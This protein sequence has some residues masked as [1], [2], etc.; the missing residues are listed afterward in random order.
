MK[1][2]LG[3]R[4]LPDPSETTKGKEALFLALLFAFNHI[5]AANPQIHPDKPNEV[6]FPPQEAQFIRMVIL[7]TDGGGEPCIDELEVYGAS[8]ERN[9]A[10]SEAGSEA[11]A[12]SCLAGH[13]IHRIE[14]LNDGEYG[15]SFSWIAAGG[16]EEWAQID[17]PEATSVAKVVFSRDRH[18]VFRDRTPTRFEIHLSVDGKEWQVVKKVAALSAGDTGSV[19]S[20]PPPPEIPTR[21]VFPRTEADET[22][23]YA[24]L[25]EEHA[26]L[27]TYG[28]ADLS[29][30][31]VPYNGRVKEYPRHVADDFL[32]LP[33]LSSEPEL[34]GLPTDA[35][36]QEASLGTV[37]VAHPYEFE[38][39]PLVCHRLRAGR[40]EGFLYL[41]LDTDRLLSSH[42][43]VV[44]S[45]DLQ[46]C[47][48]V[49]CGTA[50]LAFN[51]YNHAGKVVSIT[52]VE[53]AV[54]EDLTSFEMR[55][56]LSLFPKCEEV[57]VRVG[58]GMGGQHTP[59]M[60]RPIE[61]AFS[62]L[63]IA[64]VGEPVSGVCQVRVGRCKEAGDAPSNAPGALRLKHNIPGLEDGMSL[65]PGEDRVLTISLEKGPIG[66]QFDLEIGA[67][68]DGPYR[69]HLFRYDPLARTLAL[70]EDLEAR[71]D[72]KG[73]DVGEVPNGLVGLRKRQASLQAISPPDVASER[74]AFFEARNLKRRLFLRDPDLEPV[75]RVLF[76][77]RQPFLPSHNYS[78]CF[79]APFRPGGGIC[80]LEIPLGEDAFDPN[81]AKTTQLFDAGSG[82]A[83]TPMADYDLSK[84]YFAYRPS[85]EGYYHVMSVNPDGTGLKQITQGPFHDYWPCP[86]PDGDLAFISTRCKG[87]YLCWRPQA[88]VMFRMDREGGN[89]RPLSYANLTEWAPSVMS[90][91]RLIWTRSEYIDKGADFS[92][93]LWAIRPDGTKPELVF[94][95]TIIQPNGYAN[96]REVPDTHEICCT[97]ISHFGD[98]NGPI[99][100][101]DIDKG[102]FNQKA[103]ASITPEV[104]WPG[105]W[106]MEEC[107]RD[108][109][110]ISR[111]LILCSHA[112]RDT[113]GIYTIDRFGDRE[114]L[115]LDPDI[116]C[117]CPTPLR[118]TLPPPIIS[119][120]P[121]EATEFGE[122]VLADA[123]RGIDGAVERGRV[124]YLRVIEEVRN[125]LERLPN[126][127]YR[128]DHEP[129]MNWYVSP[130]DLVSGPF[131]WPTYVAKTS[132][133]VV[134]V[135]A[136][137]SARFYAPAGKTLYFEILDKDFNEL[138]RMRSVVQI[139][140]GE[141]RSCIGC[142][143]TRQLSPP[144]NHRLLA[145][146][147]KALEPPPWG[148]RPFNFQEVVQPV[149]D[150]KCT[151][152][153]NKD[154]EAA[155]DL[156]ATPDE[157]GIPASYRTMIAKGLV[158]Y[159][160]Y[161]WNSGGCEKLEPLTFGTVKSK[162][163]EVL[164]A[165]HHEVVLTTEEMRRLKE[166]TDLN[167]PLWPDYRDRRER[168][169][170][171]GTTQVK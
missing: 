71:L 47:G 140:P 6:C 57:G 37:R 119:D 131:G 72:R 141:K 135:E 128:K 165:G 24:F 48:V 35:C 77:K 15:N 136:D 8:G 149:L 100:L 133:G 145:A 98:L 82:I 53:A 90:D 64:P 3:A 7:E 110:P 25:G 113:F 9:L 109:F 28:R 95:N 60:G 142:H 14:H 155:I 49:V 17:L 169:L 130:V 108:A 88:A 4:V 76:A 31:L 74:S 171:L 129:F 67:D 117:M 148:Q 23:E 41:F 22:L 158:N 102:R 86:L 104:P 61:F 33:P 118:R 54:S 75:R 105:N 150:A 10:S 36:W 111:D 147:P 94:G 134:P 70:A 132:W 59:G 34:D 154:H 138:Q 87:R 156:T 30:R 69:L 103:I 161:G 2:W 167:C 91:G 112:P 92:H 106:P 89:M 65:A 85:E 11:T 122:F 16:G 51:T 66:P 97:L 81:C 151:C 12:S 101:V 32:P 120:Q 56:P 13:T 153:H 20:P 99:A 50:G 126:G 29:P 84:I 21:K 43:A 93:T 27:K 68:S 73:L 139:R 125:H 62:P 52:P 42:I 146:E 55:L 78:V 157:N 144:N 123:Y 164:D 44:S 159:C 168:L 46:G 19:P 38:A 63:S 114:V 58:L 124:K 121:E 45:A 137:G 166:W 160:D 143:E 170:T 83:R 115:Y 152:C 96:G 40:R 80:V 162:L 26:W 163:W 18:G 127:E 1:R 107:F 116:S 5:T 39:S 79:D